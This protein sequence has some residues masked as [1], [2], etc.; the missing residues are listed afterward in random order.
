VKRL[1]QRL[2][3]HKYI[4][5][6]VVIDCRSGRKCD[7]SHSYVLCKGGGGAKIVTALST[8]FHFVIS[9]RMLIMLPS[10]P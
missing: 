7:D 1:I 2:G 6:S 10:M 8:F 5:K 4:Q 9:Y 3:P